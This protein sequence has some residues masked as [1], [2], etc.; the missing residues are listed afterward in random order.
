MTIGIDLSPLQN[1]HRMRGIGY[2]LINLLNNLPDDV[3]KEHRFVFYTLP[4]NEA[5]FKDPFE[6]IHTEGFS[7]ETRELKRLRRVRYPFRGRLNLPLAVINRAIQWKD[8]YWGTSRIPSLAGVDVFLQADQNQYLPA[9]LRTKKVLIIYDLIPFILEWDYLRT[10]SSTRAKGGTR[11]GAL[12]AQLKRYFLSRKLRRNTK[13]ASKLIAISEKTKQDFMNYLSV[14]ER[15]IEVCVLGV[16][17]PVKSEAKKP[18]LTKYETT[19]WGYI[20]RPLELTP[21]VPYLLFI[22]GVDRRRKLD[23][24]V[25]AFNTLRAEGKEL[26]LVLAGDIMLGPKAITTEE[27]S[28]ALQDSS[29]LDDIIFMGFIDDDARSWLYRHALAYV[30][31]SRY[32]GFGLP[33]L[34][35]MAHEC[36]VIS[37]KNQATLEVAGDTPIYVDNLT[38][39]TEGI[40]SLLL[41]SQEQLATLRENGLQC[42]KNYSW[43]QTASA[44][45]DNICPKS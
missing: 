24:V 20:K 26:K 43:P 40:R 38:E 17:P 12:A 33:V 36:P 2:T 18:E 39:L 16:D 3:V 35:A 45:M 7:Y 28:K 15:K 6:L 25:A 14:P 10:Y 5:L 41:Y 34:E 37:Y 8:F 30:F 11:K 44:I 13:R 1:A 32:E 19:S 22:G 21:K 29:Y 31:P 4:P 23:D 27:I 9:S 42:A